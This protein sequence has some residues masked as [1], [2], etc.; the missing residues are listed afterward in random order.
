MAVNSEPVWLV[1]A[2]KYIGLKEIKGPRHNSIILRM[3]EVIHSPWFKDD[4]TPWCAGFVGFVLENVG[5]RSTRSARARSYE[6]FGIDLRFRPALGAI[7]VFT[8]NGGGH[9]G[10]IVGV[11]RSGN[12]MVLGG[13]Q[14]D[15]VKISPYVR[16]G[17]PG[18]RV[19]AVVWPGKFW[20][21]EHRYRL[22]I[23]RSDGILLKNE[24]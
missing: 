19:S 23:L 2:R 1:E 20:P 3:W 13:N 4:E 17:Q 18:S 22:P 11:D 6:K 21:A 24:A 15:M 8:R 7:V 10:F 14:A 16:Y 12:W 5:I 9:V